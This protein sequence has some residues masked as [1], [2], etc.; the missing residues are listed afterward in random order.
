MPRFKSIHLIGS[1]AVGLCLA[2]LAAG[3]VARGAPLTAGPAQP[4]AAGNTQFANWQLSNPRVVSAGQTA[5]LPEGALTTAYQ[6]EADAVSQDGLEARY[7]I[8]QLTLT[9]F[10]PAQDMP[11]QQ[12]GRWYVKGAWSLSDLNASQYTKSFRHNPAVLEGQVA[13]E[14]DYDPLAAADGFTGLVQMPLANTGGRWTSAVGTLSF[15]TQAGGALGFAAS[16]S[17]ESAAIERQLA[18]LGR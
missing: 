16:Q 6:V 13:A 4:A 12:A 5:A 14:L 17:P 18:D 1:L 3:L 11:G 9:V 8:F 15:N 7:A 10:R 2:G